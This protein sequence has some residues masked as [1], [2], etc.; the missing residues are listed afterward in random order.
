MKDQLSLSAHNALIVYHA[1]VEAM[2]D[3]ISNQLSLSVGSLVAARVNY[4]DALKKT[5][6]E[7]ELALDIMNVA[8]EVDRHEG[9][10]INAAGVMEDI[11][12]IAD[13]VSNAADNATDAVDKTRKPFA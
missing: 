1:E 5:C 9:V 3:R 6:E 11:A 8:M 4:L 12:F 2:K 13:A 10:K 7:F